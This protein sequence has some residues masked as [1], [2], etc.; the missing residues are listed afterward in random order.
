MSISHSS[1]ITLPTTLG[2]DCSFEVP[3]FSNQVE[4]TKD[5]NSEPLFLD[6]YGNAYDKNYLLIPSSPI[7]GQMIKNNKSQEKKKI[8]PFPDPT[9]FKSKIEFENACIHWKNNIQNFFSGKSLPHS[10]ISYFYYPSLPSI[11]IPGTPQHRAFKS[12]IHPPIPFNL[13]KLFELLSKDDPIDGDEPFPKQT[14]NRDIVKYSDQVTSDPQWQTQLIPQEP[15]PFL[16]NTFEE[17][18]NAYKKWANIVSKSNPKVKTNF[19]SNSQSKSEKSSF[20]TIP[21][22]KNFQ[23]FLKIDYVTQEKNN[24]DIIKKRTRFGKKHPKLIKKQ[25]NPFQWVEDAKSNY[26]KNNSTKNRKSDQKEMSFFE[27]RKISKYLKSIY[28]G[29]NNLDESSESN[30]S[31]NPC[32]RYYFIGFD[33]E[34][35]IN[36]FKEFGIDT[37]S[38][39]SSSPIYVNSIIPTSPTANTELAGAFISIS[40]SSKSQKSTDSN[41]KS[42]NL[43]TDERFKRISRILDIE[44]DGEILKHAFHETSSYKIS[45]RT[46][47]KKANSVEI[48][49]GTN[50]EE[51][52]VANDDDSGNEKIQ[53][54]PTS[55]KKKKS[56]KDKKEEMDAPDDNNVSFEL[57]KPPPNSSPIAYQMKKISTQL[58]DRTPTTK[59]RHHKSS[60][61][62]ILEFFKAFFT[63]KKFIKYLKVFFNEMDYRKFQR[64]GFLLPYIVTDT[65]IDSVIKNLL[66]NS[67]T[68]DL[69]E[70]VNND[71]IESIW[72][73]YYFSS[74]LI[75]FENHP[76]RTIFKPETNDEFSLS[77]TQLY[78]LDLILTWSKITYYMQQLIRKNCRTIELKLVSYLRS[79]KEIR[80]KYFS[81]ETIQNTNLIEMVVEM[82]STQIFNCFLLTDSHG[83]VMKIINDLALSKKGRKLLLRITYN[84][85]GNGI[86]DFISMKGL[87]LDKSTSSSFTADVFSILLYNFYYHMV[88]L[89][90]S[91]NPAVHFQL[92]DQTKFINPIIA[93]SRVI[94]NTDIKMVEQLF[95]IYR[96]LAKDVALN[97]A[98]PF[99]KR[100]ISLNYFF[101]IDQ[102]AKI[103]IT[104]PE[105][106]EKLANSLSIENN[107][108]EL[109]IAWKIVNKALSNDSTVYLLNDKFILNAL[110]TV[111]P[112]STNPTVIYEY[113]S[114]LIALWCRTSNPYISESIVNNFIRSIGRLSCMIGTAKTKFV[115]YPLVQN[116][117]NKFKLLVLSTSNAKLSPFVDL[118]K[119]HLGLEL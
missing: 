86:F 68:S 8:A 52:E 16:Y 31:L 82:S 117:I 94:C 24:P 112:D 4:I 77:V 44:F 11:F 27:R 3:T 111:L 49:T 56:R 64:M 55:K 61:M 100:L 5:E 81:N 118:F 22:A 54:E 7:S 70:K 13:L 99:E 43:M 48:A 119:K 20:L 26:I 79:S 29:I 91:Y 53:E 10:I 62:S 60:M 23:S 95:L 66:K 6:S 96:D 92:F 51:E 105:F 58:K 102:S 21:P 76:R 17:Y 108:K 93:A 45:R 101:D 2:L 107:T 69:S 18:E 115:E 97:E 25:D 106:T 37:R 72:N 40:T 87:Y 50:S 84:S 89:K 78:Y 110:I 41:T 83:P 63:P 36:D 33:G 113:V 28:K 32:S 39:Q 75:V 67:K 85:G 30:E 73:F 59:P 34:K 98:H 19:I 9:N 1:S 65:F 80:F 46:L 42:K 15:M 57:G 104:T 12:K 116:L 109:L 103:L 88:K 47:F 74:L 38:I 35:F 14:P 71:S 114:F 90:A